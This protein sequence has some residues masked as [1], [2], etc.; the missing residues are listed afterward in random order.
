MN[1]TKINAHIVDQTIQL[2]NIPLLASGG[3]NEIRVNF[4]FCSL[5]D[6]TARVAVFYRDPAKVYHVPIVDSVVTVPQEVTAE[7]GAFFMGAFGIVG[8]TTRTTNYVQ[9]DLE[10][11]ACTTGENVPEPAQD[12]YQQILSAYAECGPK[13]EEALDLAQRAFDRCKPKAGFI[14]P[15][16][17]EVVPEG[18]LLCDGAEYDREEYPELFAAIGTIWGAGDGNTTFNVPDLRERSLIGA[19]EKY[20]LGWTGGE[21]EHILTVEEM[22]SHKHRLTDTPNGQTDWGVAYGNYR[23]SESGYGVDSCGTFITKPAGENQPHNNMQPSGAGNFIIATGKDTAV[24]VYDIVMGAQAIP[25]E[26]QYGGT[27]ATGVA[28]A[29]ENLGIYEPVLLWENASPESGLGHTVVTLGDLSEYTEFMVETDIYGFARARIGAVLRVQFINV[30][31]AGAQM[32][33]RFIK[34]EPVSSSNNYT[35]TISTCD[36][37]NV[38]SDAVVT[39]SSKLIVKAVYGIKGVHE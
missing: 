8:D 12:V 25:L 24:S 2:T 36:L 15:L 28:Q 34:V 11:G 6:G 31:D 1:Y 3:V 13:A 39:D 7:K 9:L 29:R 27:G 20:P 16:A 30:W 26:V 14:Y 22:P 38:V 18:F 4:T 10:Q 35:L 17:M 21:A 5:W 32:G 33:Y 37:I 19:S 23:G